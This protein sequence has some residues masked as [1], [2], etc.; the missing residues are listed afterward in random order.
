ME[1][2]GEG[3]TQKTPDNKTKAKILNKVNKGDFLLFDRQQG[4]SNTENQ[5]LLSSFG[6][7]NLA[8]FFIKY[9]VDKSSVN[10]PFYQ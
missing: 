3:P 5:R 8:M 4:I 2:D 1:P 6:I 9:R 10:D 7:E